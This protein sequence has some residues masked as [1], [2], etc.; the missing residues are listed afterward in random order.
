MSDRYRVW[1]DLEA[2]DSDAAEHRLREMLD[3]NGAPYRAT[4]HDEY[5]GWRNY[6]T[7]AVMLWLDNEQPSAERARTIARQAIADANDRDRITDEVG[8]DR[9]ASARH[10]LADNLK[11]DVEAGFVPDLGATLAADLLNAALSDV[12]WDEIAHHL[13]DEVRE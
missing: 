11:A 6:E 8:I 5:N 2:A 9:D 3:A 7:W 4:G 10:L 13:I 1:A 12:D